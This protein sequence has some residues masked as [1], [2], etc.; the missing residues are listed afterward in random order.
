[1]KRKILI[2]ALML[3]STLGFSQEIKTSFSN[4][5]SSKSLSFGG[6]GGPLIEAPYINND[7]GL[8][9]GGKGGVVINRK[10]AIGGIGKRLVSSNNFLGDNLNGNEEASLN[11]SYWAGGLFGEYFFK[12]ENPLHISIPINFMAGGIAV[13]DGNCEI[14]SSGIFFIEPGINLEFC[15]SK[16]FIPALNVSYRQVLGSSLVNLS[17]QDVSGVNI[18]LLLK[19]G[20]F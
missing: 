8:V 16:Y 2:I 5:S 14:D 4:D 7:W 19:F 17:N 20:K 18:G 10:F 11:L 6:Y 1:M 15:I 9:I 3:F 12:L 13:N